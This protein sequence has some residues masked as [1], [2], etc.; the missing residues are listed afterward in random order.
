M[1]TV[2]YCAVQAQ[3]G[4]GNRVRNLTLSYLVVSVLRLCQFERS[5]KA[6]LPKVEASDA[7]K[8]C[9]LQPKATRP[10]RRGEHSR[11]RLVGEGQSL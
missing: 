3:P 9:T 2:N 6:A 10:D 5:S 7:E 8:R 4:E 1:V 11:H